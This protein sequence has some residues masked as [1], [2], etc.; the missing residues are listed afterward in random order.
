MPAKRILLV[1]DHREITR[2]L[3]T[4]LETLGRGYTIVDVPSGEEAVLEIGRGGIDLLIADVKLPGMDGLEVARRLRK[5]N[6]K[7]QVVII[8]G[9]PTVPEEVEAKRLG[10]VGYFRKPLRLDEFM[11]VVFNALGEKPP[12]KPLEAAAAPAEP[13]V[14]DRLSTLRRDLGANA[15]FLVDADGKVVVRAGDVTR[16]DVDGVLSHLMVAFSASMKVCKL[17]GGLIPSNVQFF[18]GDDFDIYTANV[19]QYFSIVIIFDGDRGAGQMGPVMRYGRQCADDLLNSL[20]MLGA[21]AEPEP[22]MMLSTPTAAPIPAA[23]PA[24]APKAPTAPLAVMA[25]APQPAPVLDPG[26]PLTEEELKKLDDALNKVNS[27][28]AADFW[29]TLTSEE[30]EVTDVRPD[31]LSFEQAEKL[32][33]IPKK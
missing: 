14:A 4:A 15:V 18:D 7:A 21:Q 3:R 28:A 30:A 6:A 19:G 32:G 16:L 10:A 26:P 24:P 23:R 9:Q 25:A 17:L 13:G 11:T 33:L 1:D 22:E 29:D 2:M 20:V 12:E 27:Q 31:A 8:T 5:S